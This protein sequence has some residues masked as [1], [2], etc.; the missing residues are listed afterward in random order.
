MQQDPTRVAFE[1]AL[2]LDRYDWLTHMAFADWL[3]ENGFDDEAEHQ[4]TWTPERQRREDGV[5]WLRGFAERTGL[6]YEDVIQAGHDY[7]RHVTESSLHFVQIGGNEDREALERA[8]DEL[9]SGATTEYWEHWSA[10]TGQPE[11]ERLDRITVFS[12]NC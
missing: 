2:E 11:P 9:L 7:I 3:S 12:C 8:D 4:R 1:K 5:A 10:V 6:P